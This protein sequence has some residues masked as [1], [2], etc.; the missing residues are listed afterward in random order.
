MTHAG[1]SLSARSP[2][3][4]PP[5]ATIGYIHAIRD[6]IMSETAGNGEAQREYIWLDDLRLAVVERCQ[7]VRRVMGVCYETRCF[8]KS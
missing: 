4:R 3:P 1:A 2:L 5:G 8:R 7:G 6:H